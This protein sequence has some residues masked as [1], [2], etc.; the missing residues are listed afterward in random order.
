MEVDFWVNL[1]TSLDNG[2]MFTLMLFKLNQFERLIYQY[3]IQGDYQSSLLIISELFGG[4]GGQLVFIDKNKN[5]N[6]FKQTWG[7]TI[8]EVENKSSAS[9]P[10]KTWLSIIFR[11]QYH[12]TSIQ[13][14]NVFRQHRRVLVQP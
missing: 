9:L 8:Q 12:G 6:T 13:V 2:I 11:K 7:H 4:G 10:V 14:A 3:S 5:I 1:C